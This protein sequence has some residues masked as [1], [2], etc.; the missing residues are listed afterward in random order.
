MLIPLPVK[1]NDKCSNIIFKVDIE[2]NKIIIK[3]YKGG[4][5]TFKNNYKSNIAEKDGIDD[6]LNYFYNVVASSKYYGI[7]T[8]PVHFPLIFTKSIDISSDEQFITCDIQYII[9]ILSDYNDFFTILLD[10]LNKYSTIKYKYL[11]SHKCELIDLPSIHNIDTLIN[12]L[13]YN[14]HRYLNNYLYNINENDKYKH[15]EINFFGYNSTVENHMRTIKN[16]EYNNYIN[17]FIKYITIDNLIKHLIIY[18]SHELIMHTCNIIYDN[19]IYIKLI[20]YLYTSDN[21]NL[22]IIKNLVNIPVESKYIQYTYKIP[23]D[24]SF[25]KFVELIDNN[26]FN[27]LIL[28]NLFL[29]YTHLLNYNKKQLNITFAKILYYSFKYYT[30][31]ID[32]DNILLKFNTN[33]ISN[34]IKSIYIFILQIYK[35]FITNNTS[36]SSG[37]YCTRIYNDN[38]VNIII[39]ILLFND[40]FNLFKNIN[41]IYQKIFIENTIIIQ[42]LSNISWK[43]ILK[44]IELIKYI[45]NMKKQ[46]SQLFIVD[47]KINRHITN[48]T[49]DNR[50]K[51]I[52]IDPLVMFSYLKTESD[53]YKWTISFKESINKIFYKF[54]ELDEI[55]YMKL[56]KIIYLISKVSIQNQEYNEYKQL[57][58]YLKQNI[59]IIMLND[60]INIKIKD[61]F[62]NNNLNL[63]F[64][65]KH[66]MR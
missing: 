55:D 15:I 42:I 35:S 17:K 62:K 47:G 1:Y 7:N 13:F 52:I 66:I 48:S 12:S 59:H 40:T 36:S 20:E 24:I 38:L 6:T 39:K 37:I 50:I 31:I 3:P 29:D 51:K 28:K 23:N 21:D 49:M 33:F 16:N 26:N 44:Q 10:T 45:V 65:A 56:S 4:Q 18:K 61:I 46:H 53:Y 58:D 14:T 60:R 11:K 9:N 5:P 64:L 32:D 63:G 34:K 8:I 2:D 41:T 22:T 27:I 54:I 25:N 30:D 43:N 19:P 57:I